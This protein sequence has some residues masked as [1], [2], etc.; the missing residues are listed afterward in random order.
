M[1][2]LV[3]PSGHEHYLAELG[4]LISGGGPPDQGAIIDLRA[5]WDI[6]QLTPFIP[7]R[8]ARLERHP[9][10]TPPRP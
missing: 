9:H 4:S 1:L 2:F 3:T 5:R 7:D 10:F 8:G 6:E